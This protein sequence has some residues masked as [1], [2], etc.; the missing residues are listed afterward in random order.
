MASEY[1][2]E[3]IKEILKEAAQAIKDGR[4]VD[5]TSKYDDFPV[6]RVEKEAYS[7]E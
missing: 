1:T 6:F 2:P 5:I 4:L 7:N 3:E